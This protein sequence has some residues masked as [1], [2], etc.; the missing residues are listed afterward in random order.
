MRDA[1]EKPK[2]SAPSLFVSLPPSCVISLLTLDHVML[3]QLAGLK[4]FTIDVWL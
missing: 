2:H 4:S 1:Q 3:P